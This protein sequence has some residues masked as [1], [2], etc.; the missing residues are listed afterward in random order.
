M[1][2]TLKKIL[3]LLN[4][5]IIYPI[6]FLNSLFLIITLNNIQHTLTPSFNNDTIAI[7]LH[8]GHIDFPS[9]LWIEKE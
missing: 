2:R 3:W 6:C 8:F 7:K 5:T 4:V 1:P 9:E